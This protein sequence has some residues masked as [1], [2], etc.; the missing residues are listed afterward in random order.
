M[1]PLPP[2]SVKAWPLIGE[3]IHRLWTVAATDTKAIPLEIAPMLKPLGG[4][5]LGIGESVV[6]GLVEFVA[7]IIIAGFLFS[8]TPRLVDALRG[9]L[10]RIL[11]DRGEEMVQPAIDATSRYFCGLPAL[12]CDRATG[13]NVE[14]DLTSHISVDCR[15]ECIC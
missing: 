13:V 12:N 1:I 4:R 7:A 10:R 6:L 3:Q 8:P 2:E 11:S 15:R 5:L 9:L 14:A